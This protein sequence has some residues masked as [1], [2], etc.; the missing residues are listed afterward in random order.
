[1]TRQRRRQA[2]GCY[3]RGAS[4]ILCEG[5]IC[6]NACGPWDSV[7]R[8]CCSALTSLFNCQRIEETNWLTGNETRPCDK[9]LTFLLRSVFESTRKFCSALG[10]F[11]CWLLLYIG[12]GKNAT[13]RSSIG[14]PDVVRHYVI[15]E[16]FFWNWRNFMVM[17]TSMTNKKLCRRKQA[18]RASCLLLASLQT[19]TGSSASDLTLRTLFC[20]VFVVVVHAAGCDKYRFTD[21]SQ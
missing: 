2:T 12:A 5:A 16:W 13:I 18:A 1:M 10:V 14:A 9:I 19:S 20:S 15:H 6:S 4:C 11:L 8:V 3:S 7:H 21:A 17:L